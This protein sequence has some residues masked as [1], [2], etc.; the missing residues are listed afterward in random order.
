MNT[1][2]GDNLGPSRTEG[3][4]FRAPDGTS[5]TLH[6][7]RLS[8]EWAY[9]RGRFRIYFYGSRYSWRHVFWGEGLPDKM[10][11]WKERRYVIPIDREVKTV[12]LSSRGF[13]SREI[14][15]H[16]GRPDWEISAI[17][18]YHGYCYWNPL[19]KEPVTSKW[20]RSIDPKLPEAAAAVIRA[21]DEVQEV[22]NE[23][24]GIELYLSWQW[25]TEEWATL[26]RV[27]ANLFDPGYADP[28]RKEENARIVA[29]KQEMLDRIARSARGEY[30]ARWTKPTK[31]PKKF[32]R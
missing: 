27:S 10:E 12:L 25:V 4:R 5:V 23:T 8:H 17:M 22:F 29:T 6:E 32:R 3:I 15:Q 18:E 28:S 31:G 19:N 13:T 14:A 24:F 7:N 2:G 9:L 30:A 16:L 21:Y 20:K 11:E 26:A 1:Y